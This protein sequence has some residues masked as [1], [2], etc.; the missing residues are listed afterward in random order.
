MH[1]RQNI[2]PCQ[3]GPMTHFPFC[4]CII[5]GC[6]AKY[7]SVCIGIVP[8]K[9]MYWLLPLW[10]Y[11]QLKWLLL[12][13]PRFIVAS[14]EQHSN[15]HCGYWVRSWHALLRH[16]HG[17][18]EVEMLW[19]DLFDSHNGVWL[20]FLLLM[21]GW[22]REDTEEMLSLQKWTAWMKPLKD[23]WFRKKVY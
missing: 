12:S 20:W 7:Y 4:N 22:S 11:F 17:R 3:S 6:I 8:C 21:L 18:R 9:H 14:L 13:I 1:S 16:F 2:Q 10:W 23:I 5:C 15:S 19:R